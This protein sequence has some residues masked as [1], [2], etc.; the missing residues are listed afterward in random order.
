MLYAGAFKN[1]RFETTTKLDDIISTKWGRLWLREWELYKSHQIIP[2][3]SMV[4]LLPDEVI[5]KNV[6]I[7][8]SET[9]IWKK[10]VE[11]NKVF[12]LE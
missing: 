12:G 6:K 8:S 7:Q 1:V 2:M 5:W 4:P 10:L 9:E 11:G 3:P